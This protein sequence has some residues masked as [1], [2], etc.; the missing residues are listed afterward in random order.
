MSYL[1]RQFEMLWAG[2]QDEEGT[3]SYIP[4]RRRLPHADF[5]IAEQLDG[6]SSY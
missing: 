6:D 5:T 3:E 4:Q 2:G 1:T